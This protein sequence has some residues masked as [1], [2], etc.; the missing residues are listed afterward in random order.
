MEMIYVYGL[1]CSFSD[2]TVLMLEPSV[3]N[4]SL[5]EV[6][7]WFVHPLLVSLSNIKSYSLHLNFLLF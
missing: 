2:R 3:Q 1:H 5:E 4:L 7:N 6:N